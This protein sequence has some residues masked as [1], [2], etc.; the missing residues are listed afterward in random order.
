MTLTELMIRSI[1]QRDHNF[2]S[3]LQR[4]SL[5][6]W[7]LRW[8]IFSTRGGDG[9][10]YCFLAVLVVAVGGEH[11]W[12]ALAASACA[13]AAGSALFMK[14][15]RLIG[16]RR[17][18]GLETTYLTLPDQFSFPSGHTINAFAVSVPLMMFYPWMRLLLLFCAVNIAVSRV[19]LNRHFPSDVVAGF[20]LGCGLG[21]LSYRLF[22]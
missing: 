18:S 2:M 10:L 15:K 22:S 5:P 1:D 8:M 9:W 4:R 20:L 17:P 14:L 12:V 19:L 16:R 6:R 11:R 21:Y 13:S 3:F 7:F